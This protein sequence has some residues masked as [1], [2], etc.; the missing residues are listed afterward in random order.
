MK[1]IL[2]KKETREI[3]IDLK[4]LLDNKLKISKSPP[5]QINSK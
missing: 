4:D 1:V 3:K 5:L 2:N